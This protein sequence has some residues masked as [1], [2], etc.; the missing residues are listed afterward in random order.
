[1]DSPFTIAEWELLLKQ[2][3]EVESGRDPPGLVVKAVIW[4]LQDHIF[5][6]EDD[7]RARRRK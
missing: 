1:M 4:L 2:L 7:E 3:R 5:A 6:L